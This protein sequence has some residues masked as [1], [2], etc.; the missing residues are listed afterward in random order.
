MSSQ[1]YSTNISADEATPYI[2]LRC[3]SVLCFK[4]QWHTF[5]QNFPIDIEAALIYLQ[6]RGGFDDFLTDVADYVSRLVNDRSL[7]K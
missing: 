1:N 4:A 3:E 7:V 5:L 6:D 2:F